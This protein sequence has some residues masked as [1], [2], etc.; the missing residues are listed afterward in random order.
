[1]KNLLKKILTPIIE[2]RFVLPLLAFAAGLPSLP[3]LAE[4]ASV[5][6]LQPGG[7]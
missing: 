6:M 3:A 1:M 7:R 2:R 4:E 5:W